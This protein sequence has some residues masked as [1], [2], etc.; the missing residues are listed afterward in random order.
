M[1]T[2][3][4]GSLGDIT[5]LLRRWSMG[6][7]D[8]ENEL[9]EAVFPNL[10]RLARHLTNGER[11]GQSPEPTELVNQIYF[12]LAAANKRNWKDRQHFFAIAV[13][14]MRH[15]LIDCAR[16]RRNAEFVSIAECG[17]GALSYSSDLELVVGLGCLLDQLADIN[18]SWCVVV[19]LKYFL[20]L[21]DEE[22]AETTGI[23]LRTMQR[24]CANA[25]HW[26]IEWVDPEGIRRRRNRSE[27][28]RRLNSR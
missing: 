9:F 19:A 24:M 3:I 6:N 2:H 4:S 1:H 22:A 7:R 15:Y 11:R 10:R 14:A 25:R 8:A 13:R 16:P 20:G 18:P 28:D 5:L 27:G 26:L 23:P 17:D 12:R 21:T